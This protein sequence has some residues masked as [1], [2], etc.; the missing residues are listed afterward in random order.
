MTSNIPPDLLK[1]IEE[2]KINLPC[3]IRKINGLTKWNGLEGDINQRV[4]Q[5]VTKNFY[6][7][8]NIYSLWYLEK[9]EQF[10]G[11]VA[12]MRGRERPENF[13]FICLKKEDLIEAEI[14]LTRI[15]EGKCIYVKNLHFD[16]EIDKKKAE[17][18][19]RILMNKNIVAQRC[20]KKLTQQ[21]L[22]Y[23]KELGCLASEE[24]DS[25]INQCT[26]D[27]CIFLSRE[28]EI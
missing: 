24:E 25:E 6:E 10:L 9:I 19:C 3:Y 17:K 18:L 26:K 2:L 27:T 16:A 15:T 4:Q 11:I 21:I 14:S 7:Q 20:K 28:L 1:E 5:A 13:D 8:G 12:I 23:Q 22:A